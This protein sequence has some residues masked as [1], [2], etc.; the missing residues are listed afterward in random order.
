RVV[1]R[2]RSEAA[3]RERRS[4]G[5]MLRAPP[6]SCLDEDERAPRG[7]APGAPGAGAEPAAARAAGEMESA[8]G[9]EICAA[10]AV[11]VGD[12]VCG[13]GELAAEPVDGG[14][15]DR[16][17]EEPLGA[18]SSVVEGRDAAGRLEGGP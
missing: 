12:P 13:G 7:V 9:E 1:R 6:C 17:G 10:P 14:G 5:E 16:C 8:A 2:V 11:A 4:D 18:P 3:L 15:E